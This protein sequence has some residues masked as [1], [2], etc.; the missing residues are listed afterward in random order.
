MASLS[1]PITKKIAFVKNN[2]CN[3]EDLLSEEKSPRLLVMEKTNAII[4]GAADWVYEKEF[5]MAKAF[6]WSPEMK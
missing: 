6:E 1:S 2:N 5:S 4:N 3:Y